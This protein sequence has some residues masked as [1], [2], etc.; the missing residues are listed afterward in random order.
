[1]QTLLKQ[2]VNNKPLQC[3]SQVYHDAMATR[4]WHTATSNSADPNLSIC[5]FCREWKY[6]V[7]S[8]DTSQRHSWGLS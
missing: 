3:C 4:G 1:M 8:V 5:M 7:E 2:E 6:S